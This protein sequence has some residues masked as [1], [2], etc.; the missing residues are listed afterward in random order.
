[1]TAEEQKNVVSNGSKTR[2]AMIAYGTHYQMEFG[3]RNYVFEKK[4]K[5]EHCN[6][7]IKILVQHFIGQK[8]SNFFATDDGLFTID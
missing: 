7:S 4:C 2:G 5:P 8:V 3:S 1:M 6:S